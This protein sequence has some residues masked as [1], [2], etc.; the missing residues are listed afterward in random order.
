LHQSLGGEPGRHGDPTSVGHPRRRGRG[1]QSKSARDEHTGRR[2]GA[3]ESFAAHIHLKLTTFR[4]N[5][6]LPSGD[7]T[8]KKETAT[9]DSSR[10]MTSRQQAGDGNT[11]Q[12]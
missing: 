10:N 8:H 7:V 12:S 6:E 1:R 2:H 9:Q 4:N 3:E 11:D 5:Q